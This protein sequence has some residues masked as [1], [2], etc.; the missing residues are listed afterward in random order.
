MTALERDPERALAAR[1]RAAHRADDRDAAARARRARR[2]GRRVDRRGRSSRRPASS[3]RTRCRRSRSASRRPSAP[4]RDRRRTT[5]C[6]TS[7][8]R[9]LH[10]PRGDRR[11]PPLDAARTPVVE[12]EASR[13]WP[14]RRCRPRPPAGSCLVAAPTPDAARTGPAPVVPSG[15]R[16]DA[17]A[18]VERADLDAAAI[19]APSPR[20]RRRRGHEPAHPAGRRFWC[21]SRRR[22]GGRGLLRAA[23]L[24]MMKRRIALIS[25]GGTIEKTYDELSGVLANQVSVLDVMLASLELRGVEVQRVA[26]MNKDSLEMTPDDHTLI[27]ETAARMARETRRR[28]RRPRHR[29]ARGLRRA[30][31]RA[32]RHAGVADRVHRRDAAVRAALDRCAAEPDRGAARGA[33][34]RRP[35][36]TSRCTTRCCSSRA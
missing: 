35:A 33:A 8:A 3:A 24:H 27:A 12:L 18:A 22:R 32:R 23:V 34:P 13:R 20:F 15:A 14:S 36:S 10:R 16:T 11:Q 31:R 30:R 29:S 26:L 5:T 4:P 2:A 9:S 6:S 1:H 28:R 25:T 19:R 7:S 21:S 17:A